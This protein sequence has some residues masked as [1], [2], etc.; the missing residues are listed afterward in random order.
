MDLFKVYIQF[1]NNEGERITGV[2]GIFKQASNADKWK[3]RCDFGGR[4]VV[5]QQGEVTEG[6]LT[7]LE[8]YCSFD[9][10]KFDDEDVKNYVG[11]LLDNKSLL[12]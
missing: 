6:D 10:L 7:I 9:H 3:N 5:V 12:I 4:E 8:N 11:N 1:T 2:V